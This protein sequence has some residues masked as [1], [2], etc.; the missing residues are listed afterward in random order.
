MKRSIAA[1]GAAVIGLTGAVVASAPAQAAT[2]PDC[3]STSDHELKAD[4]SAGDFYFDCIPQYGTGKA[5]LSLSNSVGIPDDFSILDSADATLNG[6]VENDA[7]SA[8]IGQS[9]NSGVII[10]GTDQADATSQKV[11]AILATPIASVKKISRASLPSACTQS[12]AAYDGAYKITYAPISITAKTTPA[13][14]QTA[15]GQ[16]GK[17]FF[18]VRPAALYLGLNFSGSS[19]D[20]TAAQCSV[21]GKTVRFGA[22]NSEA[23]GSQWNEVI[24]D[25]NALRSTISTAPAKLTEVGAPA[26][27]TVPKSIGYGT[28]SLKV[29]VSG[30]RPNGTLTVGVDKNTP[31]VDTVELGYTKVAI[32]PTL[33]I[34]THKISAEYSG[35][36][37][38]DAAVK[39]T[40]FVVTKATTSASLKLSKTK[41]TKKSTR[42]TASTTVKVPGT[43]LVASGKVS[44]SV[45]GKVVKTVTLKNGKASAKLPVFAKSGTAKVVAKYLGTSTLNTDSSSTVK[46]KVSSKK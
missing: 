38:Q 10:G 27:V 18:A 14:G 29:S 23:N 31:V 16:P 22:D 40:T 44:F 11:S 1:I 9:V 46:V 8:Y 39:S 13:S 28:P 19:F 26:K 24:T 25:A 34:G 37:F 12:N 21:S 36:T 17:Y 45:N 6:S 35:S 33:G 5:E 20:G 30:G 4:P 42:L 2:T 7:A 15:D 3:T 41:A 43:A 32:S